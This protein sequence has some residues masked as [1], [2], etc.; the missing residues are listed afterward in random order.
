MKKELGQ[1]RPSP[2]LTFLKEGYLSRS[3]AL[4]NLSLAVPF[5]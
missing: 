2:S 3:L 4:P 5:V 1:P